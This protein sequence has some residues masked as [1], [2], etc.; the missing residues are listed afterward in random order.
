MSS[1]DVKAG[2]VSRLRARLLAAS[3]LAAACPLPGAGGARAETFNL[4]D[5]T[6]SL[7]TTLSAGV[8]IRTSSPN[9]YFLDAAQGGLYNGNL[10]PANPNWPAGRAFQNPY[11]GS[12]DLQIDYDN[13]TFFYRGSF[14][15]D[16]IQSDPGAGA[17]QKLT[18][19]ELTTLG[20]TYRLLDLF[21]R[22]KYN[23][24][25]QSQSITVGSQTFNWG[26][27]SFLRNG[28]N[29]V[30]PIDVTG[31][32]SAGADLKSLYLP[33][34]AIDLKTTLPDGFSLEAFN[35]FIWAKSQL[36][37]YGSFFSADTPLS[38]GAT[39][40]VLPPKIVALGLGEYI[41]RVDD[42]KGQDGGEFGA[43]LR[44]TFDSMDG[45]S[46]GLYFENYSSRFPVFSV[47]TGE[48]VRPKGETYAASTKYYAEFPKDIQ[49]IG[50]SASTSGP[51]GSA[52]QG[53]LSFNPNQ[54]F[55]L[56]ASSLVAAD[57]APEFLPELLRFCKL[58]IKLACQKATALEDTTTIARIGVPGFDQAIDG[59]IRLQVS[60]LRL[61]D[62]FAFGAIDGT[63]V[64]NWSLAVEY[65]VD[66]IN[67]MP[68]ADVTPLFN[69]QSVFSLNKADA[70]FFNSGF[71][72][73]SGIVD[74]AGQPTQISEG[75]VTQAAF[76]MPALLFNRID[77][78][79]VVSVEWDFQGTTPA[80]VSTFFGQ[81]IAT[82][83]GVGFS[84]LQR[85]NASISY[86]TRFALSHDALVSVPALDRDYL[87][88]AISYRF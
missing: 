32:H 57:I 31:I 60:H 20:H 16:P 12:N 27:S 49:D 70:N 25:D 26:E 66:V 13:Y 63:P 56:N 64:Q 41:P 47:V 74:R 5:A 40:I 10:G 38:P 30:N 82:T 59:Y 85:W 14:L 53:E 18:H 19:D 39:Q 44:K 54:P 45:T 22:G 87:S 86:T 17:Y 76:T 61:S 71:P 84:Y 83:A 51:W 65:G 55:Q 68:S 46:V 75:A 3:F 67:N 81:T 8:S 43:A 29:A 33:V 73:G 78:R 42:R 69:P 48:P 62:I 9:P 1:F 24:F 77:V 37:P 11:R 88:L 23:E 35:E 80:P 15:F 34:P 36:D 79:P 6:V 72:T 58:G 2:T 52:L 50:L 28:L 7:D 21:L 4:G